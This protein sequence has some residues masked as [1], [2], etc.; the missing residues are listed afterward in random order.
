[1][2]VRR[3]AER[4]RFDASRMGKADL[5]AGEHL[6]VGLNAFEAGQQHSPHTHCD[7]D[8]LYVVLEGRGTLTVGEET[9]AIGPGDVALAPAGVEHAVENPGPEQL[10]VLVAMAPPPA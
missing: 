10:V 9:S 4:A 5:A 3:A 6:F 1:M 8:K 2:I 7:R